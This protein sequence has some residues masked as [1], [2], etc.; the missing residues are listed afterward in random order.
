MAEQTKVMNRWLVVVGGILIQLC[1]GAIY[2]WSVFTPSLKESGWTSQQ[3]QY[4]FSAGLVSFAVVMVL[5]GAFMM[6][7]L[8]PRKLSILGGVV[9]GLGYLLGGVAGGTDVTKLVIFY[10]PDRRRGDR[11]GVCRADCRGDALVPG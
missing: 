10:R 3:T 2:A 5:A 8:G 4:V 7:K 1:L 9:L 6:P 11:P